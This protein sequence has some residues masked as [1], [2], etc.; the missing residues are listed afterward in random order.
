MGVS[1]LNNFHPKNQR[2]TFQQQMASFTKVEIDIDAL[3][4]TKKFVKQ[5]SDLTETDP[6]FHI[7]SKIERRDKAR[8]IEREI[9]QIWK[10]EKTFTANAGE[11]KKDGGKF[12]CTFPYPY[13]N[14]RLHLGHAFSLTKA[15]FAAGY[16]RLKGRAVLF[17][18]SFHCTGMPIQAAANKLT[19]EIETYGLD[20]CMAGNFEQADAEAEAKRLAAIKALANAETKVPTKKKSFKGDKKKAIAKDGGGGTGRKKT[21]WEILQMCDVPDN[22]IEQFTDAQ[23]WL[24]YFPPHC[25]EDLKT[26]GLHADWRRSFITTDT[27]P[28]YDSFIRWQFGKLKKE[29]RIAFGKRPTVYSRLDQQACMDHDR[30]SGEGK[31]HQE[32][33]LIKMKLLEEG[34]SKL[35]ERVGDMKGKIYR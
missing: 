3:K 32:Y 5:V 10:E 14:G 6:G 2:I 28:Y 25:M 16:H 20:S 9:Q 11:R 27:N 34:K 7:A 4:A 33:T 19:R 35:I 30:S 15:D 1:I 31:G 17:P 12:M 21:Q 29:G 23:H 18:F 26:F 24:R 22:E 13:M 8:A